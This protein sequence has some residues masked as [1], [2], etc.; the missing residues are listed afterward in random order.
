MDKEFETQGGCLSL[1]YI[2]YPT[3]YLIEYCCVSNLES[4]LAFFSDK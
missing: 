3:G 2:L 4:H 1:V